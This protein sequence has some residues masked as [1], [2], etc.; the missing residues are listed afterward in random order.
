MNESS[1][2]GFLCRKVRKYPALLSREPE[3]D[4][5]GDKGAL[6]E[7]GFPEGREGLKKAYFAYPYA[8]EDPA[9]NPFR[10]FF[11][12]GNCISYRRKKWQYALAPDRETAG[13]HPGKK[14][15]EGTAL[16]ET[17]TRIAVIGIIIEDRR[18]AEKVNALLHQYGSYVIGRMGLPYEKKQVNIISVVLDAPMDAISALSGKL[19]RLPGVSARAIYSKTARG[20]CGPQ[21]PEGNGPAQ[22]GQEG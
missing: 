8:R 21:Q 1:K 14:E 17:K 20:A 11:A 2:E 19:G 7:R 18:Q 5:R 12:I 15:K 6:T 10:A 4:S 13:T 9:S 3:E 16:T 22:G